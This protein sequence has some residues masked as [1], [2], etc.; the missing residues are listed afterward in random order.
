M[1][2]EVHTGVLGDRR[3]PQ[4]LR[5]T[6]SLRRLVRE[7]ELSVSD[8]V[9]PLFLIH[10]RETSRPIPSMPGVSQHTP[11]AA[12]RL[13]SEAA[14]LG[15]PGVILFG[16]P[17]AKDAR[18]SGADDDNEVVQQTVRL[19]KENCPGITVITDVCLCEYTDH[20]H[21]GLVDLDG[22]DRPFGSIMTDASLE[23]H[24][25]VACS[26]ARAGA[27]VV[28]PSC[29]LD[30]VVG[31]IRTALDA[32]GC[33]ETPILSYAVK[34]ASA[35][36]GPFRDAADS[37]P[38]FGDRRT[39][40]MDPANVREALREARLDVEQGT[41]ML[42]VKPGMP[43]LDV[44]SLVRSTF[45]ELPVAAYQVSGE[46]AMIKAASERGWLE[47]RRAVVESLTGIKR[48]GADFILTYFALDVARWIRD[49]EL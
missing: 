42:M 30:G 9:L 34:Y 43:Y 49:G 38:A 24:A 29:M 47:E 44:L 4:R 16:L 2:Q 35:F 14:E 1:K 22:T 15:I 7:T 5:T 6:A 8:L 41:D 23:R 26:H 12:L 40:Q 19:I 31:A 36:Y 21:C 39:H 17:A 46:F 25:S 32:E 27:D 3:R 13:V 48:A 18:G 20:G 10:G 45:P 28:A 33:A 11:D 37:A